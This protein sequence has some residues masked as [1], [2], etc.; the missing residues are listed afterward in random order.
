MVVVAPGRV[1][2]LVCWLVGPCWSAGCGQTA[3]GLVHL[4][5]TTVTVLAQSEPCPVIWLQRRMHGCTI[6]SSFT[7]N[8]GTLLYRT[9]HCST[10]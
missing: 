6:M 5:A 9:M 1:A 3:E 8:F 7:G 4:Q 2:V 10:V